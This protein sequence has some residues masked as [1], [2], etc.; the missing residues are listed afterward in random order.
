MALMKVVHDETDKVPSKEEA[1]EEPHPTF[2][3]CPDT[4]VAD[5]DFRKEI[6]C[7]PSS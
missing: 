1:S 3:P 4:Q 6:E 2:G 5:F 7:L